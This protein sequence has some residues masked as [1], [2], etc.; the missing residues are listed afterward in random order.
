MQVRGQCRNPGHKALGR[1]NQPGDLRLLFAGAV[2]GWNVTRCLAGFHREI[3]E[4][5][6]DFLSVSRSIQ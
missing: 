5:S 4:L 1:L 6:A 2:A 3:C